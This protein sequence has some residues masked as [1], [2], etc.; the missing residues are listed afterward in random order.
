[1]EKSEANR[2]FQLSSD[3][4]WGYRMT[5]DISHFDSIQSILNY[6]KSDIKTFLLSRNL[7]CLVEKLDQCKFHIHQPYDVFEDLIN[8]T[9]T[10]DV[11][12]ICDHC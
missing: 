1:M 10:S 9:T 8:C 7:V 6:V 4:F 3:L 11:I 12:Y 2:I 5:I